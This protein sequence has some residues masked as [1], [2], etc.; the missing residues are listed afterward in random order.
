MSFSSSLLSDEFLSKYKNK[1]P[2]W[3]FNGLGYIVYKRTYARELENGETEEWWQTVA[4]CINGAQKIGAQYSKEEAERLFD[5]VFNLKCNFAGRMLWQLGTST[6]DRFGGN[7]LLNCFR[8]STKVLT[9]QGWKQI[10]D[11][12]GKEVEI[13]TKNGKWVTAP[14]K[15]YGKQRLMKTS[16]EDKGGNVS[17]VYSTPE[18][19]WL[20]LD[21]NQGCVD[22][23]TKDLKVNDRVPV[24]R[25]KNSSKEISP[26]GVQH[27]LVFG[28][29]SCNGYESFIDL[30]D[31][32]YDECKNYF[33][34]NRISW[35]NPENSR[36][37][38]FAGMPNYYKQLPDI[39]ENKPY[40][41]GFLA[42]WLA[43]DGSVNK[44]NGKIRLFNC[45]KEV[46][47]F[48]RDV[49]AVLGYRTSSPYLERDHNPFDS[50]C[51]TSELWS[52]SFYLSDNPH[53]L[54][55]RQDHRAKLNDFERDY[56]NW[57]KVIS[58]ELTDLEEEVYCAEVPDTHSFVIEGNILTGNCWFL[59]MNE[60]KAFLFLFENL[61]LGGG[62]GFSIRREDVHELPKIK[63]GVE[64]I[65]KDTKD[66]DFIVPDTREGWIKLLANV[67]EAFYS[68]GKSFSYSTIL[69][70]GYGEPIKG[71]GGKAS[72]PAILISG[73][74]KISSIF[75]AREG[76]KLRSI[77]VLDIC[78]IIGSV[79]VAGN[80]RRSAEIALGDPDDIL[81]LRAKNWNSGNIP[82][83]R[84][85]SN[86][87]QY[88]DDFSH[89][90][91]EFWTNGYEVNPDT[92]CANG[93]PYGF[94]NLPLSQKYGRLK[95]GLMKDSDL[96]PEDIDNVVGTNPCVRSN[97][98]VLTE[99]GQ[100][101]I[102]ELVGQRLRVW[103]GYEWSTVEPKITG[104]NQR[105]IK[106]TLS[107]GNFL[108]CTEYHKWLVSV[109]DYKEIAAAQS[110]DYFKVETIKLKVGEKIWQPGHKWWNPIK[111]VGL[112]Y[113][114]TDENV[115]C[116]EEPNRHLA[117]FNNIITGNCGEISLSNYECCNLAELYLNN[118]SSEEELQEC[119]KLLYKTQKAIAALPF[120]HEETN[121][122]V[123]KNMRLGLGV[124]GLCQSFEKIDWLDKCYVELRK[125]D[126]EW[127]E[128]RG[129]PQSI[130]LTTIKPSGTLSLLGGA[131]PG[132]HPAYSK[133]YIRT[134]RMSSEDKLVQICKDLGYHVEFLI[135]FDGVEDR[136]TVVVSFPC[137][138]P[139]GALLTKDTSLIDQLNLVKKLQS[140][141]SDNAVSITAYYK[142]EELDDLKNWLKENYKESIK[143]VSFLLHKEHGF[144][145]A[146]YQEIEDWVYAKLK[147]RVKPLESLTSKIQ[148]GEVISDV[149]CAGGACPIR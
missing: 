8:Y 84:G 101:P 141:W 120:L 73:I 94:F 29:G 77:D 15:A 31:N 51:E 112:E 142:P 131:T 3:G 68:T 137:R 44:S 88:I 35:T 70:R 111:V 75:K 1:Q 119:A 136:K 20:V 11:L 126:K 100:K 4:R 57:A 125:F 104:H 9:R 21:K 85:M 78:N 99:L 79:V 89:V 74:E 64:V 55:I 91:E 13:V 10:G 81:F 118:I 52:I 32:T 22:I 6:V 123:H 71:F 38:R 127:S 54:I 110:E 36:H 39:N 107:D 92:K 140:I 113:V 90:M 80:V 109:D 96:Y 67:L 114:G 132:I 122:I 149:E 103:N 116:F 76:K 86:N 83:W 106:V 58:N 105:M 53:H 18:H 50:E 46:L 16:F 60:P 23:L 147:A 63:K 128:K 30:I 138:T 115:Y 17:V 98:L 146:P 129:W 56:N 45:K 133:Y 33:N 62:V 102:S 148:A 5:L 14:F 42:G 12:A 66:A 130:K 143:S 139:D 108:V 43:A 97:T 69:V 26:Q 34:L 93:E 7:S 25:G 49:A 37:V 24:V 87:T 82:N 19:R 135:G 121:K 61:M 2:N 40:L 124:T 117:C 48:A 28:D 95:D 145:Q 65:H 72:G 41:T 59:S 134:I 144:T 27:G 47:E